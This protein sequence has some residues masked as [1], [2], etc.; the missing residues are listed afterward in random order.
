M[1]KYLTYEISSSCNMDCE[2]CFSDW[3]KPS[4]ELNTSES[5]KGI[6]QLVALGLE[7][8]NF[9]GG[10]PL[11]RKDI[12]EIISYAKKSGLTTILTTNGILLEEKIKSL[13]SS[14]DY[15]GLPLDS[16]NPAAHNSMRKTSR[17][18]NHHILVL[19]LV[20]A[21]SN[22]YPHVGV[23]I[24]TLVSRKNKD[25][26][27]GI[28]K[29]IE[30]KVLSWKLSHFIASGHGKDYAFEYSIS[31]GN[32]LHI[33][34]NCQK[35]HPQMNIVSCAAHERDDCCRVLSSEGHL[36]RPSESGLIDL[37]KLDSLSSYQVTEGCNIQKNE[38]IL[39][40]TYI[41]R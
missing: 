39:R 25:E 36:L 17:T 2:F 13:C 16:A 15:I 5:K 26:V 22:Q 14:L 34:G 12:A 20:D 7:A 6:D 38:H 27:V 24:N 35:T 29:L 31:K 32:Y 28:G 30:G 18:D 3:R 33:V 40:S 41:D 37:G 10:E 1:I 9:T 19:G 4:K 21:L 8:I 11:L 23:K